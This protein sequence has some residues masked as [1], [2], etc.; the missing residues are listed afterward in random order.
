MP[1][2]DY[3]CESLQVTIKYSML[4]ESLLATVVEIIQFAHVA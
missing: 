1:R 3:E 2:A 4:N